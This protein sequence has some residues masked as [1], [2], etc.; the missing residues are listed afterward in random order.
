MWFEKIVFKYL[1][2]AAQACRIGR[3]IT[4]ISRG[5]KSLRSSN[6]GHC[7]VFEAISYVLAAINQLARIP[8]AACVV[9]VCAIVAYLINVIRP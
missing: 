6:N 9:D 3:M 7:S 2:T 4:K 5:E 1:S 8:H